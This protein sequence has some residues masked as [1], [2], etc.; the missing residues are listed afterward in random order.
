MRLSI[1]LVRGKRLSALALLSFASCA[2]PGGS[3]EGIEPGLEV[4]ET[5]QRLT[6]VE[7]CAPY[8]GKNL[9]VGTEGDD[10][11]D[12]TNKGDCI[13]GLGG[14]DVIRGDN[15]DDVLLGG[16]GRDRLEG[17]N[18]K[19]LIFG[20][21]GDD[22]VVANNGK[23]EVFGGAGADLVLGNNAPD[24]LD[25]E[26]CHDVVRGGRAPDG[27]RGGSGYDACNGSGCE[28]PES[29]ATGC[30][31]SSDCAA[32]QRC[33]V[34]NGLCVPAS[35]DFCEDGAEPPD[36]GLD[37]GT[38][39][40]LDAEAESG[41]DA[42][43]DGC[44]PSASSDTQCNDVDDDCD[45]V[46]DEDFVESPT[47]CGVGACVR[48]GFAQC[49]LGEVIDTCTPGEP[50]LED[51]T[52]D[53][54]DDDC[55]G[56]A[57]EDYLPVEATCGVGACARSG[58]TAC[59]QGS[60]TGTCVP[61]SPAANDSVCN[62]VD[63]DC[64]GAADEEYVSQPTTCGTGACA[65]T[66]IATC[67]GGGVINSCA[68]GTP[69]ANDATCNGVDDDCDLA[70]DEDYQTVTTTCVV[71]GC[72][73]T[74]TR[75]CAGG[76]VVDDCTTNPTCVSE[77]AC[78]DTVDNDNDGLTDCFDSDCAGSG[79]STTEICNNT[80]D[81]DLDGAADCADPNCS[82]D[83]ACAEIP[84]D[85]LT[86]APTTIAPSP[87]FTHEATRF[88]YEGSN[89]IQRSVMPGAIVPQRAAVLRGFVKNVQG[90]PMAG[91]R[92]DVL[93][94]PELGYTLTRTDG[95]YDFVV[96]GGDRVTLK[97]SA[98]SYFVV[99]RSAMLTW[100]ET[101]QIPDVV[102]TML[103]P[104]VTEINTTG[105][106]TGMQVAVGSTS[107]DADGTRTPIVMFPAGVGATMTLSDGTI[108]ALPSLSVRA[109]EY[110]VGSR[111][112][113]AMPA[114]PA[115]NTAYTYA[116]ELSVDQA[117]QAGATKVAFSAPVPF[118]VDNFLGFPVGS[119]V[120]TGYLDRVQA[121]WLPV[122]D[123]RVI[124]IVSIAPNG[125]ARLDVTG[126]GAVDGMSTLSLL[127]ITQA[128]L[129]RLGALRPAGTT[130]WRVMLEHFTPIDHNWP[131]R[132]K[133]DV[134]F[135][136][137]DPFP[138]FPPPFPPFPP[139]P[140]FPSDP[141]P[142][143]PLPP[144]FED[145]LNGQNQANDCGDTGHS[146]IHCMNRAVSES[147]PIAGTDLAMVY[148]S[149]RAPE[150]R[151]R[152]FDVFVTG[153]TLHQDLV[154]SE[155][156]VTVLGK[157]S[158]VNLNPQPNRTYR[159]EWDGRDG[160]GR[161]VD[162]PAEAT[163]R[164]CHMYKSYMD[165]LLAA[166]DA[167]ST[168][169]RAVA[170]AIPGA[171]AVGARTEQVAGLCRSFTR[172]LN[173]NSLLPPWEISAV[174]RYDPGSTESESGN[175][176]SAAGVHSL[177]E[178]SRVSY[179][180]TVAPD[181]TFLKVRPDGLGNQKLFMLQGT[182]WILVPGQGSANLVAEA[183]SIQIYD[184]GPQVHDGWLYVWESTT[185]PLRNALVRYK[186][187]TASGLSNRQ[188]VIPGTG[189]VQ[190]SDIASA[191]RVEQLA[192]QAVPFRVCKDCG[193]ILSDVL[194]KYR[195]VPGGVVEVIHD[196]VQSYGFDV[197]DIGSIYV[198]D[199]I[200]GSRFGIVALRT[201][202]RK[203]VLVSWPVSTSTCPFPQISGPCGLNP[204]GAIVF[205]RNQK[206]IYF[207]IP[208]SAPVGGPLGVALVS[209]DAYVPGSFSVIVPNVI[210]ACKL[211]NSY[212]SQGLPYF[213]SGG[214]GQLYFSPTLGA[215]L[216]VWKI[217]KPIAS[218]GNVY[219]TFL[220]DG[221]IAETHTSI[222]NN[223]VRAFEYDG[224]GLLSGILDRTGRRVRI[225]RQNGRIAQLV[226]ADEVSTTFE[227]DALG[228]LATI[229][230]PDNG[231]S[232]ITYHGSTQLMES[233]TNRNGVRSWYQYDPRGRFVRAWDSDG[234]LQLIP[235]DPN[236]VV[237][238]DADGRVTQYVT[239]TLNG[240]RTRYVRFPDGTLNSAT[241]R[242]DGTEVTTRADGSVV[243]QVS[244]LETALNGALMP[245]QTIIRMPSGLTSTTTWSRSVATNGNVTITRNQNGR[246]WTKAYSP[247]TRTWTLTSPKQRVSTVVLDTVGRRTTITE[248]GRA[249]I[250]L[251]YDPTHGRLW[252]VNA[253]TVMPRST[254]HT[255]DSRGGLERVASSDA[256]DV[257]FTRDLMGRPETETTAGSVI[258]RE[259]YP[260]G[261]LRQITTPGNGVHDLTYTGRDALDTYMPPVLANGTRPG[262]LAATYSAM[263]DPRSVSF[264][265][266][267]MLTFVP[268]P[269]KGRI[270][271]TVVDGVTYT[272][273]YNAQ[274]GKLMSMTGSDGI[275][276]TTGYNGP[277]LTSNAW[278]GSGSTVAGSVGIGY[279]TDLN[280][281]S[282]AV[283]AQSVA[284]FGYDEDGLLTGAGPLAIVRNPVSGDI[285]STT[286]AQITTSSTYDEHGS[287]A[288]FRALRSGTAF[289][290]YSV[291]ER[292]GQGRIRELS[293]TAGGQTQAKGYRYDALGRLREV[294]INGVSAAIY[295]YTPNGNRESRQ[296]PTGTQTGVYDTQDRIDSYGACDYAVDA[297][298]FLSQRDCGTGPDTF[299]YDARGSLRQATLA[300]G[301]TVQYV[302]DPQGRRIGR[303]L[304]GA[305]DKGW[306]Y[307]DG[308]RPAAQLNGA[309]Q[310]EAIYVYG[311]Q[312][313]VP[314]YIIEKGGG[315]DVL[316]R[317]LSDHLGTPRRVVRASDGLIV[318]ELDVDEWGNVTREV[319]T[320]TGLHPFGFAG[321]LRDRDT[322]LVR[323]GAR[324]YDPYA[325]RWT[326][327]DP[328]L[329]EGAQTNLIVYAGND[330]VNR[331]DPTGLLPPPAL[332]CAAPTGV[333]SCERVGL[334]IDNFVVS[335]AAAVTTGLATACTA[336]GLTDLI[337]EL[338][339]EEDEEDH[340]EKRCDHLY[341]KVD[342]PTCNA[343][344]K[345]RGATAGARCHASASQ[346]Y[347]AC[348]K[349]QRL[350][351]LD[352]WGN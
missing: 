161:E 127:G 244:R 260:L 335:A 276:L 4:S 326:A 349:G 99:A 224:A 126:D 85:P 91:V 65:A 294:L 315:G 210:T 202:G 9:I 34:S 44:T 327:R 314:D 25:G 70:F 93:S 234:A 61:G 160:Y 105:S 190:L 343:I 16:P 68:P 124:R 12:G 344:A 203:E 336:I 23:D 340:N 185:T 130:L 321:G 63:D 58:V 316:Y 108:Q 180:F 117:I 271:Q 21:D 169:G 304:N 159:F 95:E 168:F 57:D 262:Q 213:V 250:T 148:Y 264:A 212:Y 334:A 74:G 137:P 331:S 196:S 279:N 149:G 24:M 283:N 288:T 252:H 291:T 84:P 281:S 144:L 2:A 146:T 39:A 237:K 332:A 297:A 55:G 323:F 47:S 200:D 261:T 135:P 172:H 45:G 266:G 107:T 218:S 195:V 49:V 73:A 277:L 324:D 215:S 258:S 268:E 52:C 179:P 319:G 273:S 59:V 298:G 236:T 225:V 329:F 352:T 64:D 87:H 337:N 339:S 217:G 100:G 35:A 42:E 10:V 205:D 256:S 62:G 140:P 255:Y 216:S 142:F 211:T 53:G 194:R 206:R 198:F 90:G 311:T 275:S 8:P 204:G 247:S 171:E 274:T 181:G 219:N 102:M 174:H 201:D 129:A 139:P 328:I 178:D 293:E 197:D 285:N 13:V 207:D 313:N 254:T 333:P 80:I 351:P 302:I 18:G 259:W 229:R 94:H 22:Q 141:L 143:P 28:V 110:T 325:G 300:D 338:T 106:S 199:I 72:N 155:I 33:I 183:G 113:A 228:R 97:Y 150:A 289:Y 54:I 136:I 322:G 131:F 138:P 118:Y 163:V 151:Q 278:G 188:V 37:A 251:D 56:T 220:P 92:V 222:T 193:I 318:H 176:T 330:P 286:L 67:V 231:S 208:Y 145:F 269:T 243:T 299:L 103:D 248:P 153:N 17:G 111:G 249:N 133:T 214:D 123:G 121:Q 239:H 109:T 38:E 101:T 241:L 31:Q 305:L 280:P 307:L 295:S 342:T 3:S 66:G 29:A 165:P 233:F 312:A 166:Q 177:I 40:G 267:S 164:L 320:K 82:A 115:C 209:A 76:T 238:S 78:N 162:R 173:Q 348:L 187:S 98:Q 112:L 19:D 89:P 306:L 272:H 350:P 257:T 265:N 345:R 104:L 30:H 223:L 245:A 36:G 182:E 11:L 167:S 86:V 132:P 88:L 75:S 27:V 242:D 41:A 263:G 253:G 152:S 282:L 114:E 221:R 134:P 83:P 227:Y 15:G 235:S 120:P 46:T 308:L 287:I 156:S 96:N 317:V 69:A 157:T 128:E 20:G 347:A 147:V 77:Q 5:G 14:N 226:S 79:C 191:V 310:L 7:Q 6:A 186:Y 158:V 301:D 122:A 48:T 60:V 26:G 81:D 184:R 71:G 154:R 284:S 170:G 341:Y 240:V 270:A 1:S 119:A 51:V 232:S 43:P 296:S 290:E 32:N 175:G 189:S 246:T 303:R 292:D 346:R 50:A 125:E 116:V 230:D 192:V 309:G